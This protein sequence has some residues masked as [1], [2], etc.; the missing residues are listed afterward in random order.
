[1]IAAIAGDESAMDRAASSSS[2]P[3]I[4]LRALV[5][6]ALAVLPIFLWQVV[7]SFSEIPSGASLT[8]IATGQLTSAFEMVISVVGTVTVAVGIAL[9]TQRRYP[10]L[11]PL[12][13]TMTALLALLPFLVIELLAFGVAWL[14]LDDDIAFL[15]YEL[16]YRLIDLFLR[17]TGDFVAVALASRLYFHWR[18]AIPD[19]VDV[20]RSAVLCAVALALTIVSTTHWVVLMASVVNPPPDPL[21]LLALWSLHYF[22]WALIG[23]VGVVF[24]FGSIA[25]ALVRRAQAERNLPCVVVAGVAAAFVCWLIMFGPSASDA[26]GDDHENGLIT[27]FVVG[28]GGSV[29]Y[30][31]VVDGD[32]VRSTVA[33]VRSVVND[34]PRTVRKLRSW[35]YR[36][37]E[38]EER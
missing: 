28:V 22:F 14:Q 32:F 15:T 8:Y 12:S 17:Y 13:F 36:P 23:C 9:I 19:P 2:L 5:F 11:L 25:I 38:D 30:V 24:L 26:W 33:A 6:A 18:R 10:H 3:Q 34:V 16:R 35:P 37:T 29:L 7:I 4:D 1:M 27:V 21:P 31:Q 20:K